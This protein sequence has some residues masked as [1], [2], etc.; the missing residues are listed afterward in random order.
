M[1]SQEK[2]LID[3]IKSNFKIKAELKR[4]R[5]IYISITKNS[6][7]EF[8]KWIKKIGF[9]HLSAISVTDWLEE[10]DFEITYHLWSYDIKI[11]I[12]IKTKIK[13]NKPIIESVMQIWDEN[14]Q[15]HEREMYELFG[16]EFKGN[17]DLSELFL[18]EWK[19]PP[20][21]RKDFDWRDY[22][23][24]EYYDKKNEREIVYYD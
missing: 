17:P 8:C 5:R 23:K 14:A 6:L 7:I 9:I 2:E 12:I 15:I 18:E 22:V 21:F 3:E 4:K 19:G 24:K 10:G 16:V 13:R 1:T 11:M 20:P